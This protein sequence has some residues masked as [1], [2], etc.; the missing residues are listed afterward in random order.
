MAM[1]V[2]AVIV[3]ATTLWWVPV[4]EAREIACDLPAFS[5]SGETCP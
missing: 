5:E 3:L 1:A 4:I 2:L